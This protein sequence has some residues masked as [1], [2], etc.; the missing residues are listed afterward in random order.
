MKLEAFVAAALA[1]LQ[2]PPST[3]GT[4]R[5]LKVDAWIMLPAVQAWQPSGKHVQL[6]PHP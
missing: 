1:L 2:L 6:L 4:L 5:S 3:T